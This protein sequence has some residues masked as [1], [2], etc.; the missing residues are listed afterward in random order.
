MKVLGSMMLLL[1]SGVPP[2]TYR[3]QGQQQRLPSPG[4]VRFVLGT[5][6][7]QAPERAGL[8]VWSSPCRSLLQGPPNSM[9][10]A[11][12]RSTPSPW[13]EARRLTR[14][15]PPRL[16]QLP[17]C[18][19]PASGVC[20]AWFPI[21]PLQRYQPRHCQNHED[22]KKE[23]EGSWAC[24]RPCALCIQSPSW[25]LGSGHLPFHPLETLFSLS[26][27]QEPQ[28]S[29]TS[30]QRS[31]F[32]SPGSSLGPPL[33]PSGLQGPQILFFFLMQIA[34]GL[35]Q[36]GKG[37]GVISPFSLLLD[38]AR[39]IYFCFYQRIFWAL[40]FLATLLPTTS[41]YF[42][43]HHAVLHLSYIEQSVLV[44]VASS[45]FFLNK[46]LCSREF[47]SAYYF[48]FLTLE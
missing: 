46:W 37:E 35:F 7:L 43:H 18:A 48:L 15:T 19:Q 36:W 28:I 25:V 47:I 4:R 24:P 29:F 16:N 3:P 10:W 2:H 33:Y 27:L 32:W 39:S 21:Q 1:L 31:T 8:G 34:H 23:S 26:S 45:F 30:G 20:S 40:Q 9:H 13:K 5:A 11:P 6:A 44:F 38:R 42:A 41:L 14:G 22:T 17:A 12:T